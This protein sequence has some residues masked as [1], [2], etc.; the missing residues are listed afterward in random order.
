MWHH[1]YDG[2]MFSG[3]KLACNCHN[4]YT[5]APPFTTLPGTRPLWTPKNDT[6]ERVLQKYEQNPLTWQFLPECERSGSEADDF[7]CPES[8]SRTTCE[9]GRCCS[10]IKAQTQHN[11]FYF[12][13]P[14]VKIYRIPA[15]AGPLS[16]PALP[17]PLLDSPG[18]LIMRM[19]HSR[20]ANTNHVD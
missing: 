19:A 9:T 11:I 2:V 8:S 12:L 3:G 13:F 1:F 10:I 7:V 15:L 17:L 18:I 4:I 6:A 16:Y 20:Q 14:F 5:T